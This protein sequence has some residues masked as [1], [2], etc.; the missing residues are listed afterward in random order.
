MVLDDL[1]CDGT[2]KERYL[3]VCPMGRML[4]INSCDTVWT[5]WKKVLKTMADRDATPKPAGLIEMDDS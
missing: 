4:E 2:A 5:I 1:F 3:H